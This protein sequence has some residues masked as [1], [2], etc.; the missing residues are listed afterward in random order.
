MEDYAERIVERAIDLGCQDAVAD[1][2]VNR[3]YQIRFAQNQVAISNRWRDTSA[4]VFIVHGKR[5]VASDIKDLTKIDDAVERLVKVA[6]VSQANPDYAGIAKGPFK[7]GRLSVDKRIVDLSDGSD[8]VE[9]AVNGALQEGAK[10]CAGSFWKYDEEHFLRTSNGVKGYDRRASLYMSIRALTSLE[11]SGHGVACATRLGQFEPWKAGHKAGRI[12]KLAKDPVGGQAGVYDIV[13]DPLVFGSLID[14]V[15]GRAGAW[16]VLAGLSP[17]A[18]KIGKRVAAPSVTIVDDAS[19]DSIGRKR[20]DAEGV[21]TK[22]TAIVRNGVL[23][24]YLHNTSTAKKFKTR[25][26]GNAGLI[27]PDANVLF[28]KPGDWTRDEIFSECK[29]GLWLTNTWYTRYQSYVTGDF[30]TI[31]RDGIFRI[32]KGEVV[33]AWKDVRLTDNL[34]NVWKSVAGLS[35]NVDQVMWW[36]EV[37]VPT[38]APYALARKV[39]ITRSAE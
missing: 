8:Y 31:P 16:A 14:Q 36:G 30:S 12:A 2:G 26:T 33:G 18:K 4:S 7:Y 23:K 29:D 19:A 10:E 17:F 3:S 24:T 28:C 32:K 1:V 39:R 6:K 34:I 25:T 22:R 27:A 35:K 13:F 20:F 11:S 37:S 38:F 5:V 21:P 15:G 9:A